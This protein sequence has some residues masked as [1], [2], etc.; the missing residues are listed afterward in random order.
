M[1]LL[2][3]DKPLQLVHVEELVIYEVELL[4]MLWLE[5]LLGGL[6]DRGDV[7][8]H[9]FVQP[10]LLLRTT[11]L[12][13]KLVDNHQLLRSLFDLELQK[14][15]LHALIMARG[16]NLLILVRDLAQFVAIDEVDLVHLIDLLQLYLMDP[17]SLKLKYHFHESTLALEVH[18]IHQKSPL[19]LLLELVLEIEIRGLL[20][21]ELFN[22][23]INQLFR[24]DGGKIWHLSSSQI[25]FDEV[26]QVPAVNGNITTN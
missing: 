11:F 13:P 4:N 12:L 5:L 26:L 1:L 8:L 3:I 18:R 21:N 6:V 14:S 25:F 10:S 20:V 16:V 22:T 2:L 15:L 23:Q 7:V 24:I 19:D 9:H 17:I